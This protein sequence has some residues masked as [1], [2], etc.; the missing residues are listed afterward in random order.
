MSLG[1]PFTAPPP[2]SL[3]ST[4]VL[5]AQS[6]S[7]RG[8]LLVVPNGFKRRRTNP[9][10]AEFTH[11]APPNGGAQCG[12]RTEEGQRDRISRLQPSPPLPR[13]SAPSPL[14]PSTPP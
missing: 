12:G 10:T 5:K 3:T 4:P 13:I 2:P 7:V 9:T 1:F 14:P 11:A 6:P 8:V